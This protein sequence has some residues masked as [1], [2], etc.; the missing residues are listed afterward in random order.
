MILTHMGESVDLLHS[1]NQL[2]LLIPDIPRN[3]SLGICV[4]CAHHW[5]HKVNLSQR[6][7]A[8]R[9]SGPLEEH[10]GA[11]HGNLPLLLPCEIIVFFFYFLLVFYV[12]SLY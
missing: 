5:T 1:I 9:H 11:L 12:P 7:F 4:F 8:E 3:V 2:K 10:S 6:A